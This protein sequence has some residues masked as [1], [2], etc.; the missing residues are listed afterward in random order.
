MAEAKDMEQ[1]NEL[2][3]EKNGGSSPGSYE[4]LYRLHAT[5]LK[6]LIATVDRTEDAAETVASTD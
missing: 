5:R 1:A 6:F 4:M 3:I 2:A